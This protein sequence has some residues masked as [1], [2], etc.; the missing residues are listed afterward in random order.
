MIKI[1][2]YYLFRYSSAWWSLWLVRAVDYIHF[3]GFL[4]V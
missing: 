3:L 4:F 2:G 1:S